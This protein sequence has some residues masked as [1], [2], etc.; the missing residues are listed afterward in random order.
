MIRNARN[1]DQQPEPKA[2]NQSK[3]GSLS[4]P[5]R[6]WQKRLWLGLGVFLLS[7]AGAGLT[8]AWLFI[9]R[10]LAPM[11]EQNVENILNRDLQLGQVEGFSLNSIRFGS[12]A[13]P[14]TPT[15][16]DRASIE[17][18]DVTYNPIKLLFNRTLELDI[19][20]VKP[21]AYIEQ[22]EE[23]GWISTRIEPQPQGWLKVDLQVVRVR[24]AKVSLVARG[25]QG[26]LLAPVEADVSSGKVSL[27]YNNQLF[28]YDFLAN[29]IGGG[30]LE[31][32]G[33]SSLQPAQTN[34]AISVSE[35]NI[36]EVAQLAQ[37]PI[38]LPNGQLVQAPIKLQSG[39]VGGNL[40]V[41]IKP[42][43]LPQ[44]VGDLTLKDVA[45]RV[46]QLPKPF[47]KTRGRLRLQG[48]QI[49]LENITTL[50]GQVRAQAQGIVDWQSGFNLS[51]Q[52]KTVTLKQVLQTFDFK[53]LPVEASAE[54]QAALKVTGAL[55]NPI[56]NGQVATTKPAQIDKVSFN[57]INADF[58]L[59][60]STL[61]LAVNN[62]RAKPK[63]GG[64]VTGEGEVKL[65]S[66]GKALF[67][68]QAT[69]VPAEAIASSYNLKLPVTVGLVSGST[70]ISTSLEN[71]NNLRAN[72]AASLKLADGLVRAE[73]IVVEN[74]RWQGLVRA[75]NVSVAEVIKD[76]SETPLP[77]QLQG[78]F[79]G[80]FNVS[81]SLDSFAPE[82]ISAKGAGNMN[83][84]GGL[85]T[86]TNVDFNNSLA[87]ALVQADGLQL[88]RLIEVP[89]QL[90]VPLNGQFQLALNLEQLSLQGI[91][92]NGS[93]T[94][95]LADGTVQAS[96]LVVAD[97][98]WR[99]NVKAEDVK[100]GKLLP[101]L[102]PEFSGALEGIFN[103]SGS[104]VGWQERAPLEMINANG[105]GSLKMPVGIVEANSVNLNDG[106][107][108]AVIKPVGINL[109][110]F[111]QQLQ[112]NVNGSVE[113]AGKL[114]NLTPVALGKSLRA[115][116][117]LNFSEG[118]Y[119]LD[120]QLDT[121]F[122]WNGEGIEIQKAQAQGLLAS[123]FIDV[124]L[125]ALEKQNFTEAIGDFDLDIEAN[126]FDLEKL[127]LPLPTAASNVDIAGKANFNG[128]L[129][130]TIKAPQVNGTL[131]LQNFSVAKIEFDS[132]L[133]GEVSAVAGEGASLKL[134]GNN[135]QIQLALTPDYQPDS[136]LIALQESVVS[137]ESGQTEQLPIKAEGSRQGE[138][139]IVNADNFPIA[140]L[141]DFAPLPA[142]LASQRLEGSL[143]GEL[144]VELDTFDISGTVAIA[145]PIFGSLRGEGKEDQF[146]GSIQYSDGTFILED[147][148]FQKGEYQYQLSANLTPTPTG[149][150]FKATLKVPKDENNSQGKGELQDIL[151]ALQIFDLN[152]ITRDSLFPKFDK[153][154]DL[155]VEPVGMPQ[156]PLQNQLQR[157][158]EIEVLLAQQQQQREAASPLPD[159]AQ[160]KGKFSG[161]VTVE[162]KPDTA[163]SAEFNLEGED[164][165]WGSY[166]AK[167]VT[168]QGELQESILTLEILRFQSEESKATFVGTIGGEEQSGQLKID[169]I[170]VIYVQ[171]FVKEFVDLPP[172][173]V[174]GGWV[175][176]SA[177]ISGSINNPQA[178]GE[179][180][181][182]D[183]T[184]NQTPIK[185]AQGSFNYTD[186]RLDFS[187]AS[188][189]DEDSDPL[190]VSGSLPYKIPVA[191]VK[192][193]ND[194][195]NL[196]INVENEGL[197]LLNVLS[198]NQISWKGGT[199]KVDLDIQGSFDQNVNLPTNIIA[200]GSAEIENATIE[201]SVLQGEPLENINGK[202]LF[203]LDSIDVKKLQGKFS[204]GIVN[205]EGTI[206]IFKPARQENPLSVNIGQLALNLKGLYKGSVK[207]EVE[208]GGTA[209]A[210]IISG[211]V[212]LFDGRVSLAGAAAGI[213]QSQPSRGESENEDEAESIKP[214]EFSNLNLNLLED[215]E[216]RYAPLFNFLASGRLTL[217]G[218][219]DPNQIKPRGRID[220]KRGRVNLFTTQ[221]RLDRRYENTA[222]FFPNQGLDPQLDVRLL[223][224]V[225]ETTRR[226]Q[227]PSDFSAEISDLEPTSFD[228]V[229]TVRVQ[230]NVQ[231]KASALVESLAGN[232]T[233]AL[234]LTSTPA[235]NETEIAALLGGGFV[236]T[237][238]RGETTLGLANLAGS[239]LL[240]NAGYFIGEALG[241]SEFRLYPTTIS[242][243][244]ERNSTLGLSAE[245]GLD[246]GRSFSVS[247]S[248][249]LTS[250]RPFRYNLRYRV[251]EDLLLRGSTNLDDDSRI[252]LEYETRF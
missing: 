157:F 130:G 148:N 22:D 92:G 228:S 143:S 176:A 191:T 39:Q 138:K 127:P 20:L 197:A 226:N 13:L 203:N 193:D 88:G 161:E 125:A 47:A 49:Q 18:L 152:D 1:C 220:L 94:L 24:D 76:F 167:N 29:L 32:K 67:D 46:P 231:G 160:A 201:A 149:P 194:Q 225:T 123:G 84:A 252:V 235:R 62:L 38:K 78:R 116:G 209:V 51:A 56:V 219:M 75:T 15:D 179:I 243:D 11:V 240:S 17:A 211:N 31:L 206:P 45:A 128:S 59:P 190:K 223:A 9:N 35:L 172:A 144:E 248:K 101:Q 63:A 37:A 207:G 245:A 81:G 86:V 208:V 174:F 4:T 58:S 33:E 52:T 82:S 68:F 147:G 250:P 2:S 83:L 57:Q 214:V 14:P 239:A 222:Q 118:I 205:A 200:Q 171:Q 113:V 74:G 210:P 55:N 42:E 77:Q 117:K 212:D 246:V 112:G 247:V 229:Q 221:L 204:D 98:N 158:S 97:G 66:N 180:N 189:L 163:I 64:M 73:N 165:Q 89:P 136:F 251:D 133:T 175:N 120:R 102:P 169:K 87:S 242:D 104:L 106:N 151:T 16:P 166:S 154:L 25:I 217:D 43:Q 238:G 185:I 182:S 137:K 8:G 110:S 164:W 48:T 181:I 129:V 115:N 178:R 196:K 21:N 5:R 34:L 232:S 119:L 54:V 69:D 131:A 227:T 186:A 12:S 218:S 146:T 177:T 96:N 23:G 215:I 145:N 3:S 234:K 79:N 241:L 173:I 140:M 41:A 72:A 99:A 142:E 135:D 30:N 155:N 162:S 183:A 111:S 85:V 199:G 216:I 168:A 70:S 184:L 195:L 230:A 107:L 139:L 237:L 91:T 60:S 249:E 10:K 100:L 105:S 187:A 188:F 65:G 233:D 95:K 114:G 7:G 121:S 170:P 19:T 153:N 126:D 40:E 26:N 93:G 122:V 141:K 61:T 36:A 6:K 103:L 159:L 134:S 53:N 108:Q 213:S 28:R 244:D 156:A 198:R 236:E 80:L 150:E 44:F 109:G 90:Q 124:N 50:F 132:L 192:P 71:L 224:S 202:V 27:L